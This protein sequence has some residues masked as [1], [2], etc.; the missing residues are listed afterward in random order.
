MG[1]LGT[2]ALVGL[3]S[4]HSNSGLNMINAPQ[5][6]VTAGLA[7]NQRYE[8]SDHESVTLT[9]TTSHGSSTVTGTD[10]L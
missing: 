4:D 6:A 10:C 5:A 9:I 1:F 7:V 8:P 2:A 3:L